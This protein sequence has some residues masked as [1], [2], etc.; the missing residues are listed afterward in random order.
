MAESES[1]SSDSSSSSSDDEARKKSRKK[2]KKRKEKKEK[3]RRKQEKKKR[4][5]RERKE[6]KKRK[7]EDALND[8]E[9]GD[10][11]EL[12]K[13][14]QAEAKKQA[15]AMEEVFKDVQRQGDVAKSMLQDGQ[16]KSFMKNARHDSG[17]AEDR[18][19]SQMMQRKK[20]SS[21]HRNLKKAVKMG[22]VAKQAEQKEQAK[23]LAIL[24]SVGLA[25]T[26][27]ENPKEQT[28]IQEAAAP[29]KLSRLPW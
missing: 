21:M 5:K 17:F 12:N 2:E 15:P 9:T 27:A 20:A 25:P 1:S 4:K 6:S 28:Q 18:T 16:Y 24:Q 11:G 14:K 29:K 26:E 23:M 22:E 3:K 8:V 7:R 19:F 10:V 13:A